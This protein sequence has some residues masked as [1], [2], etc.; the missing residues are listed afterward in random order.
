M[1]SFHDDFRDFAFGLV[2]AQARLLQSGMRDDP[3]RVAP[4]DDGPEPT[5]FESLPFGQRLD[6]AE[7]ACRRTLYRNS[8]I[9]ALPE[10]DGYEAWLAKLVN[11]SI[12]DAEV[13]RMA[14]EA[15]VAYLQR[16]ALRHEESLSEFT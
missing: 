5:P 3:N 11:S 7:I 12:S 1:S 14:R 16:V 2:R 10:W 6:A 13:G 9:E 8:L 15:V 4:P